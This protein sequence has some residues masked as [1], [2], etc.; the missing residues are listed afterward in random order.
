M[1]LT[2]NSSLVDPGF[3][4][5]PSNP[6]TLFQRWLS[7]ADKI[8]V[9]EPRGMVLATV[10]Y[11][12]RPSSR[13]L[14]LKDLDEQGVTFSTGE[15]SSKG[16]DLLQNPCAA[17]TLWWRE[18]VQ[19]IN[20]QGKVKQLSDKHSDAIFQ[21]R[22]R[23]AQAVAAISKQSAPLKNEAALREQVRNLIESEEQIVRPAKWYAYYLTVEAIEFWHGNKD[24]FHQRLRYDLIDDV[25]YY[26]RL[27]P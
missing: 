4:F 9:S 14:L 19:Q 12:Q 6:M 18:T 27:Q 1:T 11:E 10:D 16:Q 5:P 22:P 7:K 25:W 24:R 2:G 3:D 20:F 15:E 21:A 23:E 17:G 26:Q 13:V 8:K